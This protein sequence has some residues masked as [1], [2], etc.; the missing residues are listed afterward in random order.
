MI[1]NLT[2][3]LP[4]NHLELG[5]CLKTGSM[6]AS[7]CSRKLRINGRLASDRYESNPRTS[8]LTKLRPRIETR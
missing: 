2:S 4:T 7:A 3:G 5:K 8:A 6:S 1:P